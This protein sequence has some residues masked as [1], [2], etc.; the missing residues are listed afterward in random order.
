LLFTLAY[1]YKLAQHLY[2]TIFFYFQKMESKLFF[3]TG[4][5]TDAG[6]SI[7]TGLLLKYLVDTNK[8]AISQK[9]IQTGVEGLSED[10]LQHRKIAGMELLPEDI[11]G[12]T[13]PYVFSFPASPHLSAKIDGVEVDLDVIRKA[14]ARLTESYDYVLLEGAGG[15]HVPI[16]SSVN[17]IDF[18]ASESY[19]LILVSGSKVGSINHTLLSLEACQKRGIQIAGIVYNEFPNENRLII[20]DSLNIIRGFVEKW[21][22][23]CPIVS[24][25]NVKA[26][27]P[28]VDF[29]SFF[30]FEE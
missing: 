30:K 1:F 15:L 28:F 20:D 14:T 26:D 24:I 8:K 22:I 7:A 5:D 6:K 13:C 19:P 29:G 16:N 17:I 21:G 3:V 27:W 4:I 11:D 18:I 25:P 9:M 23:N 12:T 2:L 10:I